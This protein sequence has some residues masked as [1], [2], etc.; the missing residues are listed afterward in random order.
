M[1]YSAAPRRSFWTTRP[2]EWAVVAAVVIA[3]ITTVNKQYQDLQ[4]QAEYAAI[5]SV[6]G[7]LRT[8]M[9]LEYLQNTAAGNVASSPSTPSEPKNP[10]ALL[11]Q[12]PGYAGTVRMGDQSQVTPGNWM[13]DADCRCVG[14]R[15]MHPDW[16]QPYQDFPALWFKLRST[17]GVPEL[18]AMQAYSW[19]NAPIH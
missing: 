9:V 3:A 12:L 10:I 2:F 13:F 14:Y 4:G 7:S 8:A 16:L 17:K 1:A 6:L 19:R 11:E 5:Q 18:I 15:P